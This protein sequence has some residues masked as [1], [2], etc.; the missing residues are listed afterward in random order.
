MWLVQFE[1]YCKH[2]TDT[3]FQIVKTQYEKQ[4]NVKY[5]NNFKLIILK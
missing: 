1:T 3:R 4:K 5:L 2:K